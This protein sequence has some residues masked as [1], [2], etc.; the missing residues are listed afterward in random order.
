MDISWLNTRSKK[1]FDRYWDFSLPSAE[2]KPTFVSKVWLLQ[3]SVKRRLKNRSI[4]Q[5]RFATV[6]DGRDDRLSYTDH[7]HCTSTPGTTVGQPSL[8]FCLNYLTFLNH[9]WT[10][11]GTTIWSGLSYLVGRGGF[12]V[13]KPPA[14]GGRTQL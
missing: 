6:T 5:Y 7:R 1:T 2:V 4:G 9:R 8:F 3:M 11:A 10:V 14:K 13:I 12:R